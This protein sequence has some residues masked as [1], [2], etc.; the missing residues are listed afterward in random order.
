L[1]KLLKFHKLLKQRLTRGI[2]AAGVLSR[3][4]DGGGPWWRARVVKC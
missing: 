4:G 3:A 1:S 2:R